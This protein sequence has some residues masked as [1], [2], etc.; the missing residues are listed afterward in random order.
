M[1]GRRPRWRRAADTRPSSSGDKRKRLRLFS[2]AAGNPRG[3]EGRRG[4]RD[5]ERI[6]CRKGFVRCGRRS[7]A[8]LQCPS[9]PPAAPLGAVGVGS[10][11]TE[12]LLN[13]GSSQRSGDPT[14]TTATPRPRCTLS[15]LPLSHLSSICL[16]AIGPPTIFP[17]CARHYLSRGYLHRCLSSPVC[18]LSL[19]YPLPSFPT[20]F[21]SLCSVGGLCRAVTAGM[22][23]L[24]LVSPFTEV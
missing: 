2:C 21:P 10:G 1:E 18:Q 3:M 6:L 20:C 4:G 8:A 22:S 23:T 14:A 12:M 19:F 16:P 24:R 11:A 5:G 9:R 15:P 13:F 7:P 17:L